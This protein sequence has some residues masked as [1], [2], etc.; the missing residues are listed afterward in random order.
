MSTGNT[1]LI[2][3]AG[4]KVGA[5][6]CVPEDTANFTLLLAE[7]RRQLDEQGKG[8]GRHYQ[9]PSQASAWPDDYTKYDGR[10]FH[11]LLDFIT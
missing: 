3:S 5:D 1:R 6:G 2:A 9:L 10:R 7:F 8:D 11:P 4:V